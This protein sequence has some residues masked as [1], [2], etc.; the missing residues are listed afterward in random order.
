MIEQRSLLL[1]IGCLL[2]AAA[3]APSSSFDGTQCLYENCYCYLYSNNLTNIRCSAPST[4][5]STLEFP[6][7]L[8][9]PTA[10]FLNQ[11]LKS[12]EF[13]IQILIIGSLRLIDNKLPDHTFRGYSIR[14]LYL[15]DN[16]LSEITSRAL[17][18]IRGLE[19]LQLSEPSLDKIES[20]SFDDGLVASLVELKLIQ[21][22]LTNQK[23]ESFLPE[24]AKLAN[25]KSLSLNYNE[26]NYVSDN[27]FEAFRLLEMLDLSKNGLK[28]LGQNVFK[29]NINL[30]TLILDDNGIRNLQV[31][32]YPALFW[33]HLN[34]NLRKLTLR[35]N[36]I[37]RIDAEFVKLD[38]LNHLDLSANN[39]RE[40]NGS[41]FKFLNNLDTLY[42]SNNRIEFV[43]A[44][45]GLYL[46]RVS[47][48]YL[49]SNHLRRV[50]PMR[51]VNERRLKFIDLSNQMELSKLDDYAFQRKL[52][53]DDGDDGD[54]YESDG[55]IVN[56]ANNHIKEFTS[57]SF[58]T[59]ESLNVNI[60]EITFN[61]KSIRNMNKCL[62]RQLASR[63]RVA[64]MNSLMTSSFNR[65]V[66]RI[67]ADE[68]FSGAA[69][70]N[71]YSDV[72]SCSEF[73]QMA[74]KY[75]IQLT[76]VCA[77]RSLTLLD[78]ANQ[79][80]PDDCFDKFGNEF[81][82]PYEIKL[83]Q[84]FEKDEKTRQV[85][86][87]VLIAGLITGGVLLLLAFAVMAPFVARRTK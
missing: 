8:T 29:Y 21:T 24:L 80:R 18:G 70:N 20:D 85:G 26:L 2:T 78:C 75:N 48:V 44:D 64:N 68:Q 59:N 63:Q 22:N 7:E 33:P 16:Q 12:N 10:L 76:G 69:S 43:D 66:L 32:L 83:R 49:H 57:K 38:A 54:E 27:Y 58:C 74:L 35:M 60:K 82:C 52:D 77:E 73:N 50:P 40:I 30:R 9:N 61:Y 37:E 65:I 39:L 15:F 86:K 79:L 25:I 17:H 28:F 62:L 41:Y 42:L 5:N 46:S 45:F 3:A 19:I 56:L 84:R 71:S 13:R 1:F 31:D 36:R 11:K 47:Y 53:S 87:I 55:L 81:I 14:T 51:F 72:C 23:Y 6:I 4:A 67:N 34:M